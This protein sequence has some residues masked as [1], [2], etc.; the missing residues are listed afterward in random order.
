MNSVAIIGAGPAGLQTAIKLREAGFDPIVY[1]EHSHIG[2]PENCSGLIS[3]SGIDEL[4]IDVSDSI[5]NKIYGARIFAPNGTMMQVDR[6]N[7]VAYVVNRSKFD[8]SLAKKAH[9]LNIHIGFETKLLDVNRNTI[10]V[11]ANGRGELRKAEYVVGADGV[12]SQTRHLIGIKPNNNNYVHTMQTVATG[13]FN[14]KFV[15]VHLGN[16][17]KGFFGWVVPIS[18]TQAKIGMG[19]YLGEDVLK[20]YTE[21]MKK[22]EHTKTEAPK[23]ALIPYGPPLDKIVKDNIA[24]VGDAAFQTKATTGG[25]IVFGLKAA[26]ILAEN[27]KNAYVNKTPLNNYEK[28]LTEINRE[29]KIHWKIRKYANSLNDEQI[30]KLFSKLKDKGIEEFLEREG[31]MDEPSKFIG[32]LI[33]KPSY[34]FL[35]KNIIEF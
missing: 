18:P 34:W 29:L 28:D 30:N 7:E 5:Q 21:F 32:K 25:G 9:K 27:I 4:G 14:E 13:N 35:A 6:Y 23:S 10:F 8:Q 26:N 1:E 15:E 19:C 22:F 17:A 33:T 3:K 24:L 16:F 31:N 11:Q 2:L 20:G 12:N